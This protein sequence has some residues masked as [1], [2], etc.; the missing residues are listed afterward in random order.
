[1]PQHSLIKKGHIFGLRKGPLNC[2]SKFV[3]Y[4]IQCKLCRKQNCSSTETIY[5]YR[6]NNYR[7]K[8]Y[9]D[10]KLPKDSIVQEASFLNHFC[11]NGHEYPTGQSSWLIKP[12]ILGKWNRFGNTN[13]EHS[14][15]N[16]C[17]VKTTP[18]FLAAW[19]KE[20]FVW[21]MGGGGGGG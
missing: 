1:M 13:C 17:V 19:L 12:M 4:L 15:T 5:R 18:F 6:F 3:V 7:S 10:G 11:K 14:D 2:K 21:Y 20:T 9:I 8:L 16:V